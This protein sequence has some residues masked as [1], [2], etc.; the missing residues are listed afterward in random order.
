[1]SG[2]RIVIV[3]N[4]V[5][6]EKTRVGTRSRAEIAQIT[7][8]EGATFIEPEI[9]S[10]ITDEFEFVRKAG[11]QH[12][13]AGYSFSAGVMYYVNSKGVITDEETEGVIIAGVGTADNGLFIGIRTFPGNFIDGFNQFFVDE[14]G[15]GFDD[16]ESGSYEVYLDPEGNWVV[17][18]VS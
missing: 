9:V 7:I 2:K 17:R 13:H 4:P 15:R 5:D 6:L 10:E 18:H 8:S 12:I 14:E 1:M 16:P 11:V 3:P